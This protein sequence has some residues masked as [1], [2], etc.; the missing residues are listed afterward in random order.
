MEPRRYEAT[1][2]E[3]RQLWTP[4][5]PSGHLGSANPL[6]RMDPDKPWTYLRRAAAL[7]RGLPVEA[8]LQEGD[9]KAPF[10]SCSG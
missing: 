10:V 9:T 7:Q 6:Y 3:R 1:Q 5:M 4:N 2:P 8:D